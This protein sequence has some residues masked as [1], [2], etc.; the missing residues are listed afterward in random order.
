MFF[1]SLPDLVVAEQ[2]DHR[3]LVFV[4]IH[5]FVAISLHVIMVFHVV[6]RLYLNVSIRHLITVVNSDR[7]AA[8]HVTRV[9]AVG[10]EDTLQK[11]GE[12]E[13]LLLYL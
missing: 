12:L 7:T 13:V 4:I 1:R 10:G 5:M 8:P 9:I 11:G 6:I 2:H 3:I